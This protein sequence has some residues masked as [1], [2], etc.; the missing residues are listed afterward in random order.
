M[1]DLP[2]IGTTYAASLAAISSAVDARAD[3]TKARQDREQA[4]ADAV[5]DEAC[6][7]AANLTSDPA[8]LAEFL[9]DRME[10]H[11]TFAEALLDVITDRLEIEVE[12]EWAAARSAT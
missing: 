5:R 1:Q 11:A 12:L 7:R 2:H 3:R 8:M 9:Q 4:Y 6:E 10:R